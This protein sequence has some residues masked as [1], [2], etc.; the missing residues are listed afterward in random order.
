MT[1]GEAAVHDMS[2]QEVAEYDGTFEEAVAGDIIPK[3]KLMPYNDWIAWRKVIGKRPTKANGCDRATTSKEEAALWRGAMA[4]YYGDEWRLSLDAM[5]ADTAEAADQEASDTAGP[6]GFS[7]DA[8]MIEE[9]DGSAP[10]RREFASG[11]YSSED[12]GSD[13]NSTAMS[14][15]GTPEGLQKLL[16]KHFDPTTETLDRFVKRLARVALAME[17]QECPVDEEVYS[18]KMWDAELRA[19]LFPLKSGQQLAYLKRLFRETGNE[20]GRR[21]D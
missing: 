5:L 2:Y 4:H 7:L 20:Y 8:A 13:A 18:S 3:P 21:D 6:A 12:Q 16:D 19:Q 14:L 17:V 15:S 1:S 9:L 11:V 10:A